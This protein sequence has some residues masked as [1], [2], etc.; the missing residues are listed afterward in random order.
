MGNTRERYDLEFK[1]MIV[2]LIKDSG[3]D[4]KD[5]CG[6]YTLK[7]CTVRNWIR[8]SK[9]SNGAFKTS[10]QLALEQE[11]KALKKKLKEAEMERDILKKAVCIFSKSDR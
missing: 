2:E 4:L 1:Q 6:E 9:A 10:D 8:D 11:L 3:K 5:I 7:E